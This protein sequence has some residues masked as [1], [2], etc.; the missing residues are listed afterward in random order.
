MAGISRFSRRGVSDDKWQGK[1]DATW[2]P[3]SVTLGI[4]KGWLTLSDMDGMNSMAHN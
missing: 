2:H 4:K 1:G 3:K